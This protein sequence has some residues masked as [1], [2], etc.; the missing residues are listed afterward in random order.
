MADEEEDDVTS[1]FD[2]ERIE[3][4]RN[5]RKQKRVLEFV[6]RGVLEDGLEEIE[7]KEGG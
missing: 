5:C 4:A 2:W 6:K 7:M 1:G 3:E